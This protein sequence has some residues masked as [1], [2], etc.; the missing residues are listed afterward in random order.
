VLNGW[1][2]YEKGREGRVENY[3]PLHVPGTMNGNSLGDD[4]ES[5]EKFRGAG[6]WTAG[7][8]TIENT[9]EKDVTFGLNHEKPPSAAAKRS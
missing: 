5:S 1:G 6:A 7:V 3:E 8:L 9:W 2:I 4:W